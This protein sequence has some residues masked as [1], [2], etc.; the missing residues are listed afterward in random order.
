MATSTVTMMQR[1]RKEHY[2]NICAG[3]IRRGTEYE[4]QITM[5]TR[6]S[7]RNPTSFHVWKTHIEA[8]FCD[9]ELERF[10]LEQ[11]R[12]ESVAQVVVLKAENRVVLKV[13]LHGETI[14]ETQTVFVPAVINETE[15]QDSSPS[16][17]DEDDI[18]F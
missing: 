12:E 5:I 7:K 11:M 4:L 8:P 6:G 9:E 14:P 2:C 16:N 15:L 1:A 18:P 3:P 10:E 17:D 13:G